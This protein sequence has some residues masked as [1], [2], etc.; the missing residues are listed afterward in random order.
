M[1]EAALIAVEVPSAQ[2]RM[3]RPSRFG[4]RAFEWLTLAMAFT[5]VILIILTGWQL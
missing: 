5:V 2:A 1:A 3:A 4:D